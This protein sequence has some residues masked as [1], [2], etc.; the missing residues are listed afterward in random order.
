MHTDLLQRKQEKLGGLKI[1]S[2]A[3]SVICYKYS[4]LAIICSYVGG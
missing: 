3:W 1:E 2:V 4:Y